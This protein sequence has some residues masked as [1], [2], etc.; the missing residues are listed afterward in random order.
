[1]SSK[2]HEITANHTICFLFN[3][4]LATASTVLQ[5]TTQAGEKVTKDLGLETSYLGDIQQVTRDINH[6]ITVRELAFK[7]AQAKL[8]AK[9][10]LFKASP[11]HRGAQHALVAT[12]AAL[13]ELETNYQKTIEPFTPAQW[14]ET[15]RIGNLG[16]KFARAT[17]AAVSA[18]TPKSLIRFAAES[19]NLQG[20]IKAEEGFTAEKDRKALRQNLNLKEKVKLGINF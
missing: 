10:A 8:D 18:K 19:G 5:I 9:N 15:N 6:R 2:N 16:K 13:T 1:M 4:G 3:R 12:T 14:Q 7:D 11:N 20:L 17:Q